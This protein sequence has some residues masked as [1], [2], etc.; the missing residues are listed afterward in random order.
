LVGAEVDERRYQHQ[1]G[2]AL[3]EEPAEGRI[4]GG[5][6]FGQGEAALDEPP[7]ALQPRMPCDCTVPPGWRMLSGT[8]GQLGGMGEARVEKAQVVARPPEGAHDGRPLVLPF[9][10]ARGELDVRMTVEPGLR[11]LQLLLAGSGKDHG[12]PALDEAT[13][14]APE[15]PGSS[16]RMNEKQNP[17]RLD[18]VRAAIVLR[19]THSRRPA[20]A[21][22]KRIDTMEKP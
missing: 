20:L 6:R 12:M 3:L 10:R 11:P 15:M 17:H 22:C 9:H 14:H 1:I 8:R 13:D 16:E 7:V 2:R 21:S 19:R 18:R 5:H 4:A